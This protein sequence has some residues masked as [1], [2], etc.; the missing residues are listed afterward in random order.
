[1]EHMK[2]TP[3]EGGYSRP[4]SFIALRASLVSIAGPH[5][6][7]LRLLWAPLSCARAR[8]AGGA[9]LLLLV[10]AY[11][12][13]GHYVSDLDPLQISSANIRMQARPAGAPSRDG[14]GPWGGRVRGRER[15]T[16]Q[17][18]PPPSQGSASR[19]ERNP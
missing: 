10:R 17:S 4:P 8:R 2:V 12:V 14:G 11:Q 19:R 7:V 15:A 18:P 16:A 13:H 6:T 5:R 1:M 9:Q 3:H